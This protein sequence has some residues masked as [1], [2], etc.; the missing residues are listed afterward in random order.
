VRDRAV[1]VLKAMVDKDD[2]ETLLAFFRRAS[3]EPAKEVVAELLR[4]LIGENDPS[5]LEKFLNTDSFHLL[6]DIIQKKGYTLGKYTTMVLGDKFMTKEAYDAILQSLYSQ[7]HDARAEALIALG[8]ISKPESVPHILKA[9]DDPTWY[10]RRNAV[11][12]LKSF[13][14]P[15]LLP[16]VE[17]MMLDENPGVRLSAIELLES[18]NVKYREQALTWA[19]AEDTMKILRKIPKMLAPLKD[20]D[21]AEIY[22]NKMDAVEPIVR[23]QAARKLISMWDGL[24]FQVFLKGIAARN[25][26][27]R[28]FAFVVS[29]DRNAQE[30][31][32]LLDVFKKDVSPEVRKEIP[33]LAWEFY[34]EGAADA[35]KELAMSDEDFQVRKNAIRLLPSLGLSDGMKEFVNRLLEKETNNSGLME[36][37]F[38]SDALGYPPPRDFLTRIENKFPPELKNLFSQIHDKHGK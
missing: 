37:G 29:C 2:L 16:Y 36:I 10:I 32:R 11:E 17:R 3:T 13:R 27:L 20:K 4:S 15:K 38:A 31:R 7:S 9:L 19:V 14:N 24:D 28:L 23:I 6:L 8:K 22:V 12:A 34:R 30:A 25:W 33:G 5:M 18:M 21:L 35:I 26:R 1:E